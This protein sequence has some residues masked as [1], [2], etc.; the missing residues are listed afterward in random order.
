MDKGSRE[1]AIKARQAG[2]GCFKEILE[3][4][5]VDRG[6]KISKRLHIK[7]GLSRKRWSVSYNYVVLYSIL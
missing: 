5:R 4:S 7:Q 2:S 6:W 3:W 1:Q